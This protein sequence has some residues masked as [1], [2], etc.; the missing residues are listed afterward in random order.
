[1]I[2]YTQ[3]KDNNRQNLRDIIPLEKPFTLVIEPSSLCNYRCVMCFQS[4]SESKY[5]NEHKRNMPLDTFKLIIKQ[6][7][8]WNGNKLKVLK[9]S[10]YGEPL[11]NPDFCDMVFLAREAGIAERIETTTNASLLTPEISKRLVSDGLDYIRVSYYSPIQSKH[12]NI[13][14]SKI[15]I[16]TIKKN[17]EILQDIKQRKNSKTP[18]IAIKMLNTFNEE[19]GLFN[20]IFEEIA[21]EVYIEKPHNWVA[22]S[23]KS[24]LNSLYGKNNDDLKNEI[25]NDDNMYKAC[26]SSFY[27]LSIRNNGDVAPCCVDWIGGTN[28]GNIFITS[29]QDIWHSDELRK[30]WIMQIEGRNNENY[31]CR[32]C[33]VYRSSY[34]SKDNVD[35]TPVDRFK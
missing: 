10:L 6:M 7:N 17:L 31:S 20:A 11:I 4:T 8:E 22:T 21:D 34:Y 13:T 5:F 32:N 35:G 24:F 1:L 23:E 15:N 29:L 19:N 9:L 27:T 14:S 25:N 28:V 33:Q 26:G 3:L 16:N 2:A 18:F 12:E 30:F